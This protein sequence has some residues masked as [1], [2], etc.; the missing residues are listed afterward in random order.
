[1]I[2]YK[3]MLLELNEQK[4]GLRGI[5]KIWASTVANIIIIPKV[6]NKLKEYAPNIVVKVSEGNT[7][8]V[9]NKLRNSELDVGFLREISNIEDLII[10]TVLTE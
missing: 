1:M 10:H 5:T 8:Y 3:Q 4:D 2:S 6:I 9:L 7:E